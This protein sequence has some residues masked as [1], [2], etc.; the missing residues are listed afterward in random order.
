MIVPS[1]C[2]KK[3]IFT[4]IRTSVVACFSWLKSC[5]ITTNV[6]DKRRLANLIV[7]NYYAG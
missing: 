2:S 1:N 4:L 6:N 5:S 3:F 7:Y